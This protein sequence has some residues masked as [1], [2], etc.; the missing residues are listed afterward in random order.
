M[1]EFSQ[2][3]RFSR[4]NYL[5]FSL[6]Y[7]LKDY[8]P[9]LWDPSPLSILAACAIA[10]RW[11]SS[12]SHLQ[13]NQ[14]T[15][16][17]L[18]RAITHPFTLLLQRSFLMVLY[19]IIL[20]SIYGLTRHPMLSFR[21][22]FLFIL[23]NVTFFTGWHYLSPIWPY[24]KYSDRYPQYLVPTHLHT[25]EGNR[26]IVRNCATSMISSSLT[27][28]GTMWNFGYVLHTLNGN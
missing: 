15:S 6:W 7:I 26:L 19:L 28:A 14:P 23:E 5:Y 16:G 27:F 1:T 18:H 2:Y 8:L 24:W 10:D 11:C 4:W 25:T 22:N 9:E 13:P 21:K 12:F 17:W 3:D 20:Y